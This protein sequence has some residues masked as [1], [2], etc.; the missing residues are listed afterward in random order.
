MYSIFR[1]IQDSFSYSTNIVDLPCLVYTLDII[2]FQR[3]LGELQGFQE[4]IF[5]LSASK[6]QK[7]IVVVSCPS[8]QHEVYE[9]L[10]LLADS[11]T[12]GGHNSNYWAC[13][14]FLLGMLKMLP[15]IPRNLLNTASFNFTTIFYGVQQNNLTQFQMISRVSENLLIWVYLKWLEIIKKYV[16]KIYTLKDLF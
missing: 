12:R 5:Q 14:N 13:S 4:L 15:Q 8:I 6:L 1:K 2:H 7:K 10:P 3:I 11:L 16:Y 9:E